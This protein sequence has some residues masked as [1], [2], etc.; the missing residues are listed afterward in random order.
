M[1]VVI[2]CPLCKK[3]A[4]HINK[5]ENTDEDVRQCINCGY[6]S[7][8]KLKGTKEK[9]TSFKEFSEFVQK[10]S[11][12]ANGHIWFP[13]MINLPLGSLYPVEEND[14]LKWAFVRITDIPE[15][16]Q[17]NYPD[18]NNPGKFLSKKLDFDNQEI[19]D[20]YILALAKVR[21][22]VKSLNG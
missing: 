3:R 1:S 4:L 19:F 17:K 8:T 6:A 11:K 16:E 12:E 5:I 10:Y 13:S 20:E 22:E 21:D 18:E 9:N 15:E 2:D 7:N 14:I